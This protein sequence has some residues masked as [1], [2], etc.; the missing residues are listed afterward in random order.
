MQFL[1]KK[2]LVRTFS[3]FVLLTLITNLFSPTICEALTTGPHQPEYTSYED[4]ASTD[5]VNLLTGDFSLTLPILTVPVGS[6]GAFTVPL[7]YHAG[8]GLD[9]EASWVG[10]GWNLNVGAITRSINGFPD[11]AYKEPQ[12]VS[13]RD[14]TGRRGWNASFLGTN[15]GWDSE[16]GHYGVLN[17]GLK[18]G[19]NESGISSV[20][21]AG[22]TLAGG[23]V[24]FNAVE[25]VMTVVQV[26][27]AILT[28]GA[29]EA[30]NIGLKIA[31]DIG[32]QL[33]MDMI[34]PDFSPS[35]ATSGYWKYSKE[36]DK[37][38]FHTDYWIWL[39][40]TRIEDMYGVLN[41]D[42]VETV[43][44][45]NLPTFVKVQQ[46]VGGTSETVKEFKST[47][48][49]LN[50][51]AAS[52][53]NIDMSSS[54]NYYENFSPTSLAYDNYR[55]SA[56]G[57][58]GS[59]RPNR[60]EIGSVSVPREMTSN[61][62]RLAPIPFMDYAANKVPFV[63]E[64]DRGNRY[65]H[66]VG[67]AT[68]VTSPTFY[69]GINSTKVSGTAS[70]TVN[71]DALRYD[72]NDVIFKNQR[73]RTDAATKQKYPQG[74]FIHWLTNA[75][76]K[77]T[78]GKFS[79]TNF[80]D[81]MTGTERN[82]FR[83]Q[84][85]Y[86]GAS[87]FGQGSEF[88]NGQINLPNASSYFTL[89]DKVD[90]TVNVYDG[91]ASSDPGYVRTDY[92][93]NLSINT[94][95]ANSI[96]VAGTSSYPTDKAV[97]VEVVTKKSN[98][99]D[100]AMA[101]LVIT[102]PEGMNYHFA[103]P[104]Y[105]YRFKS[106]T[107]DKSDANKNSTIERSAPFANTWLLTGI[108][109]PDFV[110]RGGTNNSGNGMIDDADWGYWIKFN[111]GRHL[112]DY[113][114]RIPFSGYTRSSDDL[115]NI[116]AQG[117]K[118]KYYLNTIETRSHVAVFIKDTRN[119]ARDATN[120]KTSL[121]LSEI[122]LLTKDNYNQLIQSG[123]PVCSNKIDV[124]YM[125]SHFTPTAIATTVQTKAIRRVIFGNNDYTLC[126]STPN[127]TSGKLTLKTISILG[128]GN[129]KVFPDYK[130][131]YQNNPTYNVNRWD[132]WGM[133][134]SVG[135]V[136]GTSHK[137]S[138]SV[139]DGNAWSLTKIT[140]PEGSQVVVNY[141]R[142]T[143]TSISG[144]LITEKKGGNIRV[145]SIQLVD[146]TGVSYKTRY[147]YTKEDGTSSGVVSQE[148][149][150]IKTT[151]YDFN[152]WLGYPFTPVMYSRVSVLSGKLTSDADFVTKQVFEFETPHRS[153]YSIN[154]GSEKVKDKVLIDDFDFNPSGN[155][156]TSYKDYGS[157]VKY[158]ISKRTSRMGK[159]R[160]VKLMDKNN[161]IIAQ[162]DY[163]YTENPT[164]NA[165]NNYQGVFSEGS[166]MFEIVNAN[167]TTR[168]HKAQRTTW[169]DYPY[170][171]QKV[172]STRDGQ[173]SETEYKD[174]DLI[175]GAV[176]ETRTKSPLGLRAK[177]VFEP[178][179]KNP[180]YAEF[181]SKV[182]NPLNRNMMTQLA[183]SYTY[184]ISDAGAETGLL[185]ASANVWKKE[186]NNY[187]KLDAAGSYTN[188]A[189]LDLDNSGT[190]D[191][192][193][194]N[195]KAWRK[196]ETYG[197]K[198]TYAGAKP[199]GSHTFTSSDKFNFTTL[200]ANTKWQRMST[201]ERYNHNSILLETKD[202]NGIFSASKLNAFDQLLLASA[203][204]ARYEEIAFSSA[205]DKVSS[206]Y[207]G[208][209]VGIASGTIV[210]T[211]AHTGKSAVSL[212]TGYSFVFK[213]SGLQPDKKYRASV[214]TNSL[215]GR[216]YYKLN[217]GPEVL[218]TAPILQKKAGAW[219]LLDFEIPTSATFTSLE[220]GVKSASGTVLFD[221]FRFQPADASMTCYVYNPDT[222]FTEYVLDNDNFYTR[223]QYN[224]E[225]LITR[226]YQE[227]IK[228]N[229]EKLVS[230]SKADFRR[231]HID[232]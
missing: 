164:N 110:D 232:Q 115:Y 25:F 199:D 212:S 143:Y 218:S 120:T 152:N 50:K 23:E 32:I 7:S 107:I 185:A 149:D 109:G 217:G 222:K 177:S 101:G 135:A 165:T 140:T 172:T 89:S 204:N 117:Y 181:G 97:T 122:V 141:E 57:I 170:I 44:Y 37:D 98:K 35:V 58:S 100:N 173:T 191:A 215:N 123:L 161:S 144:E 12:A 71:N 34:A 142:D 224:N 3:V 200:S 91:P 45:T 203:S 206:T 128:R 38:L 189:D 219:Y 54:S 171:L 62:I 220:V 153:Q 20:G 94:I 228:Y 196:S 99:K 9:Q 14:L 87:Y 13:V 17:L 93:T 125:A 83:R 157:L 51:G 178:A 136:A 92:Y 130:F 134:S 81:Y 158:E 105:D 41:L 79:N 182:D 15:M 213:S 116:Y 167:G 190:V 231:F 133:Y 229:G 112:M 68:A 146:P 22:L 145:G 106:G 159:L 96:N 155:L 176:L 29:S 104:I 168:Y 47:E 49:I 63:Y 186:W 195:N 148:P 230:E 221:D 6:E 214:W 42:K 118:E 53:I 64:G 126:P 80:M 188:D 31:M 154:L 223:Y 56:P 192:N 70:S 39:D 127:S 2:A 82:L 43:D 19:Y 160:S 156:H 36:T 226:T 132:G 183:A 180:L 75:E 210:T 175:T 11:D 24:S 150:Y 211:S 67:G 208:G 40:K 48:G 207:F 21:L 198:G 46:S 69:Q 121:R 66:H 18:V 86:G 60:L 52:D 151:A 194:L 28:Y 179:Y 124:N 131:E 216:I 1:R 184:R 138:T 85:D 209:E 108:T 84:F 187:R 76:V 113:Q 193:E 65:F 174:W 5:M 114:W 77:N 4:A 61:H 33:A 73:I 27:M 129:A 139:T 55:V 88:V 147:L 201:I 119:D 8:I 225:G 205:E 30:A 90:V 78:T 169:L 72:L 95:S 111:Y 202:I 137:A 197:W 74:N 10:L 162:E 26:V 227:S 166:L 103:L 59:I 102:S 16:I 163:Q